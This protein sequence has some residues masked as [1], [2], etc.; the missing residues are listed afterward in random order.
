MELPEQNQNFYTKII[1]N[2]ILSYPE[3][4]SVLQSEFPLIYADLES[5]STNPNCGCVRKVENE[6]TQNKEK[7]LNIL[8]HFLASKT[9]DAKILEIISM[10]YA[11]LAPIPLQGKMFTI[12][13]TPESYEQFIKELFQNKMPTARGFSTSIGLDGKLNIYFI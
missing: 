10:D 1:L 3:L 12:D 7:A 2:L 5:A 8:N 4:K 6:L 13:N 9:D 11:A